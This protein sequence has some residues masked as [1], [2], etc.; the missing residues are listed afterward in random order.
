MSAPATFTRVYANGAG[1]EHPA[2]PAVVTKVLRSM[3]ESAA[4]DVSFRVR[5]RLEDGSV[6]TA[7][8]KGRA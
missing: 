6:V 7:R 8:A 2:S 5:F 1:P 3:V 4:G